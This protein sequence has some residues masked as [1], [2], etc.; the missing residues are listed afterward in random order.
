MEIEIKPPYPNEENDPRFYW[1]CYPQGDRFET[2]DGKPF[3][4]G[5]GAPKFSDGEQFPIGIKPVF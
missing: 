3:S 5:Q 4:P 1:W 2:I